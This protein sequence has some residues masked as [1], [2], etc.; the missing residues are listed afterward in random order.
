MPKF[1]KFHL[2]LRGNA[3][4]C[5]N[6][7]TLDVEA[8]LKLLARL[9]WEFE[10]HRYDFGDA[11]LHEV[12]HDVPANRVHAMKSVALCGSRKAS[13]PCRA[14]KSAGPGNQALPDGKA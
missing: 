5:V 12:A 9:A 1:S 6:L 7:V 2:P 10:L 14:M 8:L 3:E 11:I 13:T 4:N